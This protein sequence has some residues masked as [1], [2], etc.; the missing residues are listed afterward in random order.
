MC[1]APF[2]KDTE[3]SRKIAFPEMLRIFFKRR[4]QWTPLTISL[5]NSS[6]TTTSNSRLPV[7]LYL[8]SIRLRTPE[9]VA[10]ACTFFK[11]AAGLKERWR[12]NVSPPAYIG[13]LRSNMPML[14]KR[15]LLKDIL[16]QGII[17]N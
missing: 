1:V 3:H 4:V 8:P 14:H 2:E 16:L 9:S 5:R 15:Y 6:P 12:N 11:S 13:M 7:L 10:W 17:W